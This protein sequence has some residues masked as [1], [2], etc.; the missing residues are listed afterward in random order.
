MFIVK[1][2]LTHYEWQTTTKDEL[3]MELDVLIA[4]HRKRGTKETIV[5]EQFSAEGKLLDSVTLELPTN[6]NI[7]E[8]LSNFGVVVVSEPRQSRFGFFNSFKRI[9][10]HFKRDKKSE[11]TAK[12][13]LLEEVDNPVIPPQPESFQSKEVKRELLLEIKQADENITQ[14]LEAQKKRYQRLLSLLEAIEG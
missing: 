4:K 7:D 8:R 13:Q 9:F 10:G 14:L 5:I 6:E 1:H 11:E 2:D 12:Q 3:L